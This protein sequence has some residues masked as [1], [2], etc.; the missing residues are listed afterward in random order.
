MVVAGKIS[1]TILKFGVG[2]GATGILTATIEEFEGITICN[3]ICLYRLGP[4]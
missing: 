2:D 1:T 4:F 3:W